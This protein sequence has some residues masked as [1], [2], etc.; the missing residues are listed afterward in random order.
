MVDNEL[1][2]IY[3]P[4]LQ[5]LGCIEPPI[6]QS[7]E[8]EAFAEGLAG[9]L[10]IAA[11]KFYGAEITFA[12]AGIAE[13]P[14]EHDGDSFV[15]TFACRGTDQLMRVRLDPAVPA[16]SVS[17]LFGGEIE[18]TSSAGAAGADD[19]AEQIAAMLAVRV[20]DLCR[21]SIQS[22]RIEM[23]PLEEPCRSQHSTLPPQ[24]GNVVRIK[25]V[26]DKLDGSAIWVE[27]PIVVA[28]TVAAELRASADGAR[29]PCAVTWSKQL[30]ARLAK[31][32]VD[33]PVV[34]D[35]GFVPLASIEDI[36]PGREVALP[37]HLLE[38][39]FIGTLDAEVGNGNS[40]SDEWPLQ[41]GSRRQAGCDNR[42]RFDAL[43][44]RINLPA[45][46]PRA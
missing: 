28:R 32:P 37:A 41:F 1:R 9:S 27:L 2:T 17:L 33:V 11:E 25:Y 43:A 13:D 44:A 16:F 22:A 35:A 30:A 38:Q 6:S 15:A 42:N 4:L 45:G 19:F 36:R 14:V 31:V 12:L 18:P 8:L 24:S 34:I 26:P 10:S 3:E 29:V 46:H 21:R 20:A 7:P 5:M 39:A 23:Q 40:R